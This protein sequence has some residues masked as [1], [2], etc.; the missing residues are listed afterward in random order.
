MI[1]AT[2]LGARDGSARFDFCGCANPRCMYIAYP[3]MA[4]A[5]DGR[6]GKHELD[7]LLLLAYMYLN[8]NYKR[9][10]SNLG[11]RIHVSGHS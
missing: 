11:F 9:K 2:A 5:W 6:K 10:S 1:L 3:F 7:S 4:S 8:G